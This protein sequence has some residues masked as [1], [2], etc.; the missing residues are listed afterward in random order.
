MSDRSEWT[1]VVDEDDALVGEV[2]PEVA[3]LLVAA[4][5]TTGFLG[6]N[7]V[8]VLP[9]PRKHAGITVTVPSA[10]PVSAPPP[11][12]I[13]KMFTGA[14][15]DV[16]I[17]Y[18]NS[19]DK[20]RLNR[21]F[22]GTNKSLYPQGLASDKTFSSLDEWLMAVHEVKQAGHRLACFTAPKERVA[23]VLDYD[24][25]VSYSLPFRHLHATSHGVQPATVKAW[26][27]E[28]AREELLR[29]VRDHNLRENLIAGKADPLNEGVLDA[30]PDA[31]L[32]ALWKDGSE[33]VL[34]AF[35]A[36][37]ESMKNQQGYLKSHGLR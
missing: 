25:D 29:H 10:R 33:Q 37:T 27:F 17:E 9:H 16:E 23:V 20:V 30:Q 21:A 24:A 2:A 13:P 35:H 7:R 12:V 18:L 11:P 22:V 31:E 26:G 19:D 28:R 4:E 1:T 32:E 3:V 15:A 8:K 5:V 34:A 6:G 14:S 36:H